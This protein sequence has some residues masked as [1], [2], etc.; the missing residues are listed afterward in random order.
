MGHNQKTTNRAAAIK[1]NKERIGEHEEKTTKRFKALD[2]RLDLQRNK[3]IVFGDR[4]DVLEEF[5]TLAETAMRVLDE[6]A[7]IAEM[8]DRPWWRKVRD[9]VVGGWRFSIE[10]FTGTPQEFIVVEEV[11]DDP[12]E[13]R[14]LLDEDEEKSEEKI[15]V[16][17]E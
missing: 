9:Y 5:A 13:I 10:K 6:R 15:E 11:E 17:D 2:Q 8:N 1:N 3:M 4:L 16:E 14:I 7:T 12:D